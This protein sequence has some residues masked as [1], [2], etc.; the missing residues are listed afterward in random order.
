MKKH[1][2]T[3]TEN[4]EII[5]DSDVPFNRFCFDYSNGFSGFQFH[6]HEEIE[7]H[8][9][10]KGNGTFFIDE[11]EYVVGEG[12]IVFI[13]PKL[14]HSGKSEN[15]DL[16]AN[17]YM[18]DSTYLISKNNMYN[19][20]RFFRE[21]SDTQITNPVIHKNDTGYQKI[22]APLNEIDLCADQSDIVYQLEIKKQLYDLFIQL[23][24]HSYLT[25][26]ADNSYRNSADGI[27]KKSIRYIQTNCENRMSIDEIASHVGLSPS[28]FMKVF[29]QS[30]K[31]TCVEYIKSFRLNL[32]ITM[33]RESNDS[34][35]HIA[36]TCGYSNLSLFNR[37]FK[38]Y[39]K[40]TPSLYR[41]KYRIVR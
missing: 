40:L 28:Y 39:Y 8:Y 14:I 2:S 18:I 11:D 13:S 6:W 29:K 1:L 4:N 34:I 31:M 35:L 26:M 24:K 22:K 21:L 12:D 7:I 25:S 16:I 20:D 23:Y 38:K 37:D 17:C 5:K 27:I 3:K 10:V 41:K 9:I 15:N 32:A 30:T 33:L 19:T 36:N